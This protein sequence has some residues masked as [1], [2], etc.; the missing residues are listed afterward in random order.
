LGHR[1][2]SE[3]IPSTDT[4]KLE[5][6]IALLKAIHDGYPSNVLVPA[7]IVSRIGAAQPVEQGRGGG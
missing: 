2:V 6:C 1:E 3:H 4:E 7:W 5:Q